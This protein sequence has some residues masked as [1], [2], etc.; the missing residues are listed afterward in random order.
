MIN[1]KIIKVCGMREA[2]NIQD[3]ESIEGIDMLGFIFYPKSPRYVY[4]LPAYLPIHARRVGVFVNEDKQ[5]ISM[6][7]DRFGLNYVQ[8]HGNESPEYCRSL[9]STGLKIIK[10]FSVDRPK[11][12]RKVYDYEKVCDLFLFDTKCEQYGGSG[13]Q[14]DWS[15]LDMYNGHVPFLLSGG[16]NSYSANALKE[17]KHPRLA[18]YDLNSRFELK[19]GEKDPERIRT[20]LNE[21]KS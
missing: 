6:Y 2:E 9:H 7:A 21:L 3:V 11:D 18:G 20:F 19:P 14:F 15:I 12:L 5:T 10:G 8:L 16:I 17:F 1:G 4:E 13:N